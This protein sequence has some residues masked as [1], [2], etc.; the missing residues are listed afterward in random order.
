MCVPR[1][2]EFEYEFRLK[3][4][5]MAREAHLEMANEITNDLALF[6]NCFQAG[7]YVYQKMGMVHATRACY[8]IAF[9][10]FSG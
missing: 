8:L 3:T 1:I 5:L 2:K 6:S 7:L 4:K 10:L 9:V